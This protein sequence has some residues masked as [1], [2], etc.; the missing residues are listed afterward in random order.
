MA[1][2]KVTAPAAPV[3]PIF[4]TIHIFGFGTAQAIKKDSNVQVP[5]SSI[6]AEIF[7]C[8]EDIWAKRPTDFAGAKDDYHA[9]NIFQG[10]HCSWLG[11]GNSDSFR[12][13]YADLDATLFEALAT[14]IFATVTP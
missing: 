7:T 8:I 5:A 14:T 10:L 13:D 1:K 6:S 12:V 11:K 3:E 9:I 2:A 4:N